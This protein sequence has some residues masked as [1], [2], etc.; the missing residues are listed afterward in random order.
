[1]TWFKK[2]AGFGMIE[3]LV[4][5]AILG[6]GIFTIM[7]GLDYLEKKKTL[8][9][10]NVT[11]ENMLGSIVDSVRANIVMEKVDFQAGDPAFAQN[12]LSHSTHQAIKD[13]LTMCWVNDG[14]IS[15]TNYPNC[16]GRLGYVVSPMRIDNLQLRG[17]YYVTVRMT[18]DVLF[19]NT[20]RQ[21]QFIVRGP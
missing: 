4:S 21:Y 6:A 2:Q 9:D 5:F 1:M 18:H 12:W 17:L 3:V 11:L 16:P 8:T 13:S 19:P 7:E 14:L 10:K 20:F 15:I